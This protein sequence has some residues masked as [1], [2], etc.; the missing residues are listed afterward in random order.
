MA[1]SAAQFKELFGG[2]FPKRD[3]PSILA[4]LEDLLARGDLDI[5][6]ALTANASTALHAACWF[7]RPTGA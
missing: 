2:S 5:N 1:H 4:A 7:R 3:E 6:V